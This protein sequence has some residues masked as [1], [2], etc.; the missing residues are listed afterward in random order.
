MKKYFFLF[1]LFLISSSAFTQLKPKPVCG[2]F[3]VDVLK[4]TVSGASANFT[5]GQIKDKLPC[6]TSEEEESKTAKCGGG[7]FYKDKDVYFYTQRNYI[8]I[9]PAFKGQ[10]SL[11]LMKSKRG[12]LFNK[13][14]NP[15]LKDLDWDAYQTQYGTLV[16]YYNKAALV[17]KIIITTFSTDELDLCQ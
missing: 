8:E 6:P 16:L 4:G 14:G 12:S 10:F 9:G 11:P 5:I 7:I 2:T 17:N 1:L 3:V 15:K 13:L